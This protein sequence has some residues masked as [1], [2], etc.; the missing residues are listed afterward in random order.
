MQILVTGAV[1]GL[2]SWAVE[3]FATHDHH[4]VGLDLEQPDGGRS[5]AS[6]YAC[7]LTDQG[8]TWELVQSA[9]PDAV[10]HCAAIPALCITSGTETFTNNVESTYNTLVAAGTVGADVVWMSSESIYGTVFAEETWVPEYLPIDETHPIRPED[11]Y[12][13]SKQVGE[14]I[15]DMVV[16]KYGITVTSIRPSWINY[17]GRYDTAGMREGFDPES[18][19]PSGN[20]WS[21]VDVR[22]VVSIIETALE[23]R[24]G[25]HETY[26]AAA[27][28]NYL[29]RPTAEV[30]EAV[31][32]ELPDAC[33]ITGDESALSTEKAATELGWEPTHSWRDA[34][35]TPDPE[36]EP[37]FV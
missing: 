7:D 4:V 32:G 5:N 21:Y 23:S 9:D 24:D 13:T 27:A 19:A 2:G 25:G 37:S 12:G 29:D 15:A 14:T 22:D 33:D 3:Q 17:P 28:E 20:F 18:A 35:K 34:E 26:L 10:V 1:G 31:F 16:E 30:I 36:A 8:Q 6:F 11:P